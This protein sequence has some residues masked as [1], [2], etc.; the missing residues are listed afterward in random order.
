[1][2][3]A[4]VGLLKNLA[5]ATGMVGV[6][7]LIHFWGQGWGRRVDIDELAG[8]LAKT[9]DQHPGAAR[10]CIQASQGGRSG[11][12]HGGFVHRVTDHR[13]ERLDRNGAGAAAREGGGAR[14][15]ERSFGAG[16]W[17]TP[18]G[19]PRVTRRARRRTAPGAPE[20]LEELRL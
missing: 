17:D 9:L 20:K 12:R 11:R 19:G 10:W 3:A 15:T 1:M 14:H 2:I 8:D 4:H 16:R 7:V 18:L 13:Q 6:T 5:I